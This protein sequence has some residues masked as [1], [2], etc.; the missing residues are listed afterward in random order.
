MRHDPYPRTALLA[1][2]GLV[3]LAAA[4]N[5]GPAE[6]AIKA[7]EQALA[8]AP[9]VERYAPE[10]FAAVSQAV[11]G[12]RASF[13]AG[14][15]T[16]ALRAVQ[17][18]PDR[19]AAA[20]EVATRRK[21]DTAAAWA[22]LAAELPARLAA[23]AARLDALAS[24]GVSGERLAPAHAD[25]EALDTAWAGAVAASERGELPQAVAA[26]SDVK[27]KADAVA[28]RLGLKPAG[29]SSASSA[30]RAGVAEERP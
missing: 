21:A 8:G 6:E 26:G 4:C 13:A 29:L 16:D 9:E 28:A 23:L 25:L 10:E 19:I 20:A 3:L 18:L 22:A 27:A 1:G 2:L 12:A 5:K 11:R 30:S 14:R 17:P 15:Y 24:A 7:A